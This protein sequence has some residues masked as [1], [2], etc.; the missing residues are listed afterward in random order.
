MGVETLI[1]LAVALLIALVFY[2]RRSRSRLAPTV[3][4]ADIPHVLSSLREAASRPAFAVFLFHPPDRPQR[5]DPVSLQFST[6]DGEVGFD[7]VLVGEPNIEDED[8]FVDFARAIGYTP[9]AR[10]RSDVKYLRVSNGDLAEL[11]VQVLTSMYEVPA[12]EPLD[13]IV[14]GFAW[15]RI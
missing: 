6:E 10:E 4:G 11:A 8:R 12:S 5:R 3:T 1:I 15:N 7:W 9:V 13:L 14:E 2:G